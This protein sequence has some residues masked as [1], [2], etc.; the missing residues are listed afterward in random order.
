MRWL[1]RF[2]LLLVTCLIAVA[3]PFVPA[4][5]AC[6][7]YGMELSPKSGVPGTELTVYGHDFTAAKLVDI[8]YDGTRL[9]TNR[10]DANGEFA[11]TFTI[12]EGCAGQHKVLADLG[13]T[14]VDTYFTA[15]P[16][17]IV[18]PEKGPV[19]TNVTVKGRGFAKNEQGIDLRYY[20]NG[21]YETVDSHILADVRGSWETSFPIPACT[22][23]E[24]KL[25]AEGDKS[26]LFEVKGATFRVTA[27]ISIDKSSGIV[28]DNVTM[29][30]SAFTAN[31]KGIQILFDGE[32][33]LTG[34]NADSQGYWEESFKVPEMPSGTY[35]VTA[36]GAMTPGEDS[37]PLMFEIKPGIVLSPG[38]GNVGMNL[39]VIGRGF[40]AG[41]DVTIMYDGGTVETVES[42]GQGSFE[43]D[44]P[45][46]ESPH[47]EHRVAA[48]YAGE[49]HASAVLTV[50]S[51]PPPVP[52]LI[53]PFKGS[54][55]GFT[56][57][58]SP[59]FRWS[60]VSDESGVRYRLQIAT[61]GNITTTGEFV[62]PIVS[63][64]G[65]VGTNYTMEETEALPDGTYYWIVQAV[66]GAE[67]ES[68]WSTA[69]SFRVGLLPK[70]AFIVSIVA[71]VLVIGA[72]VYFFV[73]RR[74]IHYY[75]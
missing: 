11:L 32:T 69:Y 75:E 71:I 41:T 52:T 64:K 3:L 17:L 28:G 61:S 30:G 48:G 72:L 6:V 5:A 10:T 68:P 12:P 67:N 2:L 58:A 35:N 37:V 19:G 53:S 42:N 39:T 31:E 34:I 51:D 22:N 16:G 23:G 21:S 20:L 49:N 74:R 65:L 36:G 8:Y 4:G 29:R 63:V 66:D 1:C 9:A 18:S 38:E 44:L 7:P 43:T 50:E 57:S 47:G 33:A 26:Q 15:E 24:H 27:E 46:P 59:T 55:V 60:A 40:A 25:D 13:Y 70:W 62:D 54:W 56:G 45:V 73:I 14:T